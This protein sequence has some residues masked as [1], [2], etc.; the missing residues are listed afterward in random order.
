MMTRR[1]K[2]GLLLALLVVVSLI[3]GFFFG[4]V[5]AKAVAKKKDNP[6]F[7]RQVA[8]KQLEKVHPT[9]E[10]RQKFERR[11][12]EAVDELVAIRKETVSRAEAVVNKAVNDIGQQLTPEQ[13]EV[14]QKIKPKPAGSGSE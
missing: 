14:Y 11:V 10:Q 1:L 4:A 7:W 3:T 8:M 2:V 6:R 12:N 13:Q 5:A 9:D